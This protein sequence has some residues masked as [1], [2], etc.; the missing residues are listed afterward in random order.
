MSGF[1]TLLYKELLRFW[2]VAFQTVA[3]PVLSALLYLL[4]FAQAL[5]AGARVY[6]GVP[7]IHI[8]EAG[9]MRSWKEPVFSVV[10]GVLSCS[11][12]RNTVQKAIQMLVRAGHVV[13]GD[14]V[15]VV[16]DILASGRLINSI[17]LRN[18]E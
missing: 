9:E 12:R 16:S 18:V 1:L 17:Q 6:E 8:E 5:G 3:G 14:K 7:Y 4:I 15:V 2:K 11:I 13:S 10:D